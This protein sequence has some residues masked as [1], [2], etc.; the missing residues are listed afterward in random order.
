[1]K[2]IEILLLIWTLHKKIT[3]TKKQ[4]DIWKLKGEA[5]NYYRKKV[6]GF[7]VVKITIIEMVFSVKTKKSS[8]IT[9][10]FDSRVF[11][12]SNSKETSDFSYQP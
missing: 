2:I 4:Q 1:M 8:E 10:Q 6:F 11:L 9:I 7:L 12:D 3:L 5:I